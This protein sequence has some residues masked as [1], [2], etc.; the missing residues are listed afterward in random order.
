MGCWQRTSEELDTS[1]SSLKPINPALPPHW[2]SC[3]ALN[4][5]FIA[6]SLHSTHC[7]AITQ[8]LCSQ[9]HSLHIPSWQIIALLLSPIQYCCHAWPLLLF[10]FTVL[11]IKLATFQKC[12]GKV[13]RTTASITRLLKGKI[14]K[15]VNH[16]V[17]T[18]WYN[19]LSW[20]LQHC[21]IHFFNLESQDR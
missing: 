17:L 20:F 16:Y 18:K 1:H 11:G 2:S 4:I 15:H 5:F 13:Y 10:R 3:L 12:D 9:P 19:M 8:C 7:S 14:I 6:L 21:L